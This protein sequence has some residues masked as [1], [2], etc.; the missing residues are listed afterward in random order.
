MTVNV[1][2][3]K[4]ECPPEGNKPAERF[5]TAGEPVRTAEEGVA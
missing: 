1:I 2:R 3:I 5:L 4:E